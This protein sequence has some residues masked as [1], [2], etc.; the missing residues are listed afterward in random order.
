VEREEERRLN[1]RTLAIASIASASAA[2]V[3]SQ[4]WIA[5]TWVA[6]ALTPVLVAVI[7][8]AVHRPT[9][10]IARAWTTERG[11]S[12]MT[13]AQTPTREEPAELTGTAGPV[14]VYRQTSQG[15]EPAR[16]GT[17]A[18][19]RLS[20][21]VTL[22][23]RRVAIGGVLATAGIAFLIALVAITAGDLVTGGSIG[24]GSH[25]TTFFSGDKGTE[26]KQDSKQEP[27][28]TQPDD[29]QQ[30]QPDQ[31][32][33]STETTPAQEEPQSDTAPA[34]TTTETTPAEPLPDTPVSP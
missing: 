33:E 6:A 13:R 23:R 2:A 9:E 12:R 14:R 20:R 21:P 22:S 27:A 34:P 24:K 17:A 3:T 29:Q 8:E 1:T 19:T 26:Q 4:L 5:G 15:A 30:Q 11:E 28:S 32:D 10:R 25:R 31:Q 16:R 7:S 18:G